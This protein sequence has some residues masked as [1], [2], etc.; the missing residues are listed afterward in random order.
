MSAVSACS[1]K[2]SD[3]LNCDSLNSPDYPLHHAEVAKP[4]FN[5]VYFAVSAQILSQMAGVIGRN[6]DEDRYGRLASDIRD[7]LRLKYIGAD[8]TVS[9][10]TQ[11]GYALMLGFDVMPDDRRPLAFTLMVDAL[12]EYTY[13]ISTGFLS[14]I[15]MMD[16][17]VRGGRADLAY[18]LL[19]SHRFPSWLYQ[20]DQGA[21]TV[22]E[23]WDGYVKGHGFQDPGMNSFNHYA[24][25]SVGEW[26]YRH[27]LGIQSD[28]QH[29]GFREFFIRPEIGRTLT[30]ARGAYHSIAGDIVSAWSVKG[31]RLTLHVEVPP[32]TTSY[33][34]V[35][36]KD[37]K[38]VREG[39]MAAESAAGVKY[40]WTV[41]GDAVYQVLPGAYTFTSD[42]GRRQ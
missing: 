9:G 28:P 6:D 25:G 16:E 42:M 38:T 24:I 39:A 12:K 40:V 34:F 21:T 26:M 35:R 41:E 33:V 31:G 22:W 27:I 2:G 8:G 20:I 14:T 29:P 4:I 23:R 30:W 15:K 17:L 3:W 13:R 11:A 5:T 37:R 10:T 36:T 19:E 18:R 7:T 1:R 32:G